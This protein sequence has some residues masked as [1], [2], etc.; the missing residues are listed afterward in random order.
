MKIYSNANSS[1]T[2]F[3]QQNII[4]INHSIS[5]TELIIFS[6]R[7]YHLAGHLPSHFIRYLKT[8][9]DLWSQGQTS[10]S[11]LPKNLFQT[12]NLVQLCPQSS[13][14]KNLLHTLSTGPLILGPQC[15]KVRVTITLKLTT[16]SGAQ[17][18]IPFVSSNFIVILN[19]RYLLILWSQG[20]RSRPM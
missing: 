1:L 16:V 6:I 8:P 10:K 7:Y 2:L 12:Q 5:L 11:L 18:L 14:F 13:K 17:L 20:Q 19:I 15:L 9:S 3:Y 4:N